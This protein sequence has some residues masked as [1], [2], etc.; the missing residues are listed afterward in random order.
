MEEPDFTAQDLAGK[1][2][3][4]WGMG[5]MGGSLAL[6]LRDTGALLAGIDSSQ[7]VIDLALHR[8]IVAQASVDPQALL[9]QADLLVL[10]VPIR[11]ILAVLEQ[12]PS[13]CPHG[14]TVLDLGSTKRQVVQAMGRLPEQFRAVGGHPMCG[15]EISG[16]AAADPSIY[17]QAAFALVETARSTR[18]AR[19]L[20][21]ALA[22]AV[23]A[24]PVWLGADLHDR[25]VAATSQAPLLVAS[26]L[27]GATPLDAQ[28]MVG[29]G[30]LSTTRLARGGSGA[31]NQMIVDIL[32]TNRDYI[33]DALENSRQGF[34]EVIRML[35]K[36]DFDMLSR[37]LLQ[38]AEHLQMLTGA[39]L[40]GRN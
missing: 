8:R 26:I 14:T 35:E 15:K 31:A 23:Q 36:A 17:R 25:L 6:A 38:N 33:L 3:V 39:L 10:A 29:P 18:A 24:R 5:L 34:D 40:V 16:L 30:F 13:L 32:A 9:E 22:G 28:P 11:A 12:L 21:L 19:G 2:I 4:I 27:A 7:E 20:A 1:K 37:R